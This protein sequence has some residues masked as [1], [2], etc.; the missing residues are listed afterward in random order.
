MFKNIIRLILVFILCTLVKGQSVEYHAVIAGIN[1]Y[2]PYTNDLYWAVADA[3]GMRQSLIA[4]E[5]WLDANIELRTNTGAA[6]ARLMNDIANMPCTTGKTNLFYFAGHGST[7]GLLVYY[8]NTSLIDFD[9]Y[10]LEREISR[11]GSFNQYTAILDACETGVFPEEMTTGVVLTA[12]ESDELAYEWP[13]LQHGTFT[14]YLLQGLTN[15]TAAGAD[16]LLSAEDL[17]AYAD[18]LTTAYDPD[19]HP[20][21]D[22]NYDGDLVLNYNIYVP[23]DQ[24]PSI[25]SALSASH[26]G[27]TVI[28]SSGTQTVSSNLT[29]P[30]GVTLVIKPSVTVTFNSGAKLTV[31]GTLTADGG[32]SSTPITFDFGSPNSSTEN[33][34]IF[35]GSSGG[36]ID[37]CQVRNAYRGIYE[38]NVDV[39]I[40]NSAISGC[41]NG[42]YLYDSD[43][44][45][46]GC[47]IHDNSNYGITLVYS[48]PT[49]KENYIQ[50]NATG[51]Y[52]SSSSQPVI[53]NNSTQEG[54]HIGSNGYGVIVYDNALPK[55][56]DGTYGGYN[57]FVNP[58]NNILNATTNTVYAYNNW[59]G[60]TDPGSFLISGTVLYTPYLTSEVTIGTPPLSKT[61]G[62]VYAS[63]SSEIPMLS[64]LDKAYELVA[65]N[66][67]A[68]AR[69]LCLDLINNYPDYSVSY[70]ALNLLQDT[71]TENEKAGVK[72]TYQS[73]FNTK[74]KKDLYAM[75]GLILAN[76]DKDNRLTH[77][78]EVIETYE[79]E[80]VIELALFNKFVYYYFEEEDKEKARAI[81]EELDSQFE[82]TRGAVDAHKILGDE[83]Y[84]EIEVAEKQAQKETVNRSSEEYEYSLLENYPNPFNPTTTI[85]YTLP[86]EGRVL[87]KIYDALGREVETLVNEIGSA[88]THKVEWNGSRY[89]SGIYFY[90]ITF[91]DKTLYKKMLMVK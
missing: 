32:S 85:C 39:D 34:I 90:S 52:C 82:L 18:P 12:C 6:I 63:E 42:I 24:Y 2:S 65:S 87:I 46:Q 60:T 49:I 86:E 53:G 57:N 58:S 11:N 72:N 26:S 43:P 80:S 8:G 27:Q 21:L 44:V 15:N 62:D 30:S 4:D 29:V 77:I 35:T 67:L 25:S 23:T 41:T 9:P 3:E 36:T 31:N 73:L 74:E 20:V 56:G 14:Y 17:F 50:N 68:E 69:E 28:V 54:N 19:M 89:S 13:E 83:E 16:G 45:I 66:N 81:S 37:Y 48:S 88:G 78:E 84:Y 40:T 76:I 47:N 33:G 70:N 59:W 61:G 1:D 91:M 55:I 51:I 64:E 79:G 71:Y 10:T 7:G 75:A 38:N 22:D 5:G